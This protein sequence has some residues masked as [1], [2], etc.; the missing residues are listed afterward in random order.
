MRLFYPLFFLGLLCITLAPASQA[1][2]KHQTLMAGILQG[3][4]QGGATGVDDGL[5]RPLVAPCL[6][7]DQAQF[8]R[9]ATE[10][11]LNPKP[12]NGVQPTAL[13]ACTTQKTVTG[14]E[15]LAG[16]AVD[17]PD[18]G[19]DQEIPGPSESYDPRGFQK[20]MGGTTGTTSQGFR[21][22]Y[23]GGWQFWHPLYTFQIPTHAVGLAP[24]RVALF[25][26]KARQWIQ[27]GGTQAAWGFRILG[28]ALHYLQDLS[29][30][31]HATQIPS[32]HMVPWYAILHW[33]PQEGFDSLVSETSHA[34]TNYHWAYEEY[35]LS[36]IATPATER[37]IYADCLELPDT[38]ALLNDDPRK[39]E[40]LRNPEFLALRTARASVQIAP[41]M[42]KAM[43]DFFGP[44][45]KDR[46]IDLPK[47]QGTPPYMEMALRP[48]LV[49]SREVLTLTTCQALSN[50][51]W[52]S[53]AL[54]RWVLQ[55]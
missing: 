54:I 1:W 37:S 7:D 50:A 6:S 32:L 45:L 9:L 46:S 8:A 34:M 53:R 55:P 44:S 47:K 25:A 49:L 20:W 51:S 38:A 52:A 16:G 29:Q 19:M 5:N 21:H 10:F 24:E 23:F 48:D 41:K 3:M 17:D 2:E 39:E 11:K 33:P 30:P 14:R 27:A 18:Q 26:L 4:T 15:I 13:D 43:V 12:K 35:T 28:W 42:G 36:R 22:M 31:F 40:L